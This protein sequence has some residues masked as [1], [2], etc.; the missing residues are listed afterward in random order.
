MRQACEG[1]ALLAKLSPCSS[2]LAVAA[3]AFLPLPG[4]HQAG[5][6]LAAQTT[7]G[8]SVGCLSLRPQKSHSEAS[9]LATK[10]ERPTGK[11]VVT[12]CKDVD[13]PNEGEAVV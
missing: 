11:A 13:D 6:A 7:T 3:S 1:E 12:R 8:E 5:P 2:N 9:D 4:G 10:H